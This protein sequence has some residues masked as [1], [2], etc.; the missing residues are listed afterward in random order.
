MTHYRKIILSFYSVVVLTLLLLIYIL[1]SELSS[2]GL[3]FYVFDVGQGDAIFIR[4]S[5]KYNILID[6]GAD[7]TVVYKLGKYLPFYD[8]DIDLMI[9]THP[10]SDHVVGLTEVLKR[11]QVKKILTTGVSSH[12]SDY[13]T[14]LDLIK[15]KNIPVEIANHRGVMPLGSEVK[16]YILFPNLSLVNK[17]IKNLNNA[18]IVAKLIYTS[19]TIMLMGDF[20]NE[21]IFVRT[22]LDLSATILKVGHHGSNTANSR[23]FLAMVSPKIAVISCGKNNKFGHPNQA[24]IADLRSLGA[25]IWPTDQRGD[26]HWVLKKN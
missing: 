18:S 8:R 7:N 21:E 22:N 4:T 13:L 10:H 24:V 11:Y 14:W 17:E 3:A 12:S 25:E 6:G 15:E 9:L 5:D 23:E 20:E 1:F 2:S 19:T 26:F 16:F